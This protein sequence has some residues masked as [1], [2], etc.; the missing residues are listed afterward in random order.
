MQYTRSNFSHNCGY[1]LSLNETR[2]NCFSCIAIFFN[3]YKVLEGSDFI[4]LST[5]EIL[6]SIFLGK[7]SS[8]TRQVEYVRSLP[9]KI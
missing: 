5:K 9:T 6:L 1:A 2:I 4:L 7:L 3:K 8:S